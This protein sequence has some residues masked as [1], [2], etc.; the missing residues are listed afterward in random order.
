MHV[1]V[2]GAGGLIG[3]KLVADLQQQ[4][5]RITRMVRSSPGEGEVLWNYVDRK[6]DLAQLEAA[7]AVV[8]LAGESIAEGRWTD[9][10]KRRIRESR[11]AGTEFL[12]ES[13]ARLE[14][15]PQAMVC[16]SAIGYYGD[17][18]DEELTEDS[19]PGE[20]FL[21]EV[22]RAWESAC[23][24]AEEAGVRVVNVRTGMVL[25]AEGGAL[26]KMLLPFKLGAGGRVSS[27]RQWWSWIAMDDLVAA[28]RFALTTDSLRGPVNGTSPHP[29]T[30]YEF[31]KTL[32]RV[33]GRPTIFPMPGFAA[34]LALGEMAEDLLLASAR[35]LPRRLQESGFSFRFPELESALRHEL[36]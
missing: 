4:G 17:R 7:D 2:T 9:A 25:A 3:S 5:H 8:H 29:V 14:R 16:S 23:G 20:G 27:G 10:K 12:A 13:L 21:P 31:T 24:A 32:G 35:V 15:K 19:S 26:A 30:N 18:S 34:K 11:V 28:L 6:I 36:R 22:C 33:L 1:F